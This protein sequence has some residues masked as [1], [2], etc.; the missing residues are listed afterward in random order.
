MSDP[1]AIAAANPPARWGRSRRNPRVI[2]TIGLYGSASTWVF[3]VLRELMIA[4]HGEARVF[5]LYSDTVAKVIGDRQALGRYV[6]WKMHFGEPAWEVFA[7][8]AEP[9]I[10]LTLRDPRDAVL[11]QVNRFNT[12]FQQAAKAI[13][14]CCNRFMQCAQA[15]HPILR[16]EDGFFQNS[17]TIR[18]IAEY[19][20]VALDNAV[21][22]RIRDRFSTESVHAF[23]ER[24]PDLPAER[25][26]GDP[27]VDL[28]DEVTQIHRGHIGDGSVGKWRHQLT[29][30]QQMAITDHFAPFLTRFGYS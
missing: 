14:M 13:S 30:E 9:T 26:K 24:L 22:D 23:A 18:R 4:Q 3:N 10:L 25:V 2:M 5:A 19:I 27:T 17:E 29:G 21:I 7:Q 11:S 16:Y 1:N 15:G 28:Y 6:V 12:S 20:G 8:L